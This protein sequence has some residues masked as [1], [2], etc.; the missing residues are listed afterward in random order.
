MKTSKT[1]LT[2]LLSATLI[3]APISASAD[4]LTI[5]NPT[6]EPIQLPKVDAK[7]LA[8]K[9]AKV[10]RTNAVAF[11]VDKLFEGIDW[12]MDPA[13]NQAITKNKTYCQMHSNLCVDNLADAEKYALQNFI[14]T[15]WKYPLT[16]CQFD[17]N[18][19]IQ[20]SFEQDGIVYPLL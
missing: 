15:E 3:L 13:N 20:C 9:I 19:N 5:P 6:S 8:K 16:G 18:Q 14:S 4:T 1:L 11:A 7:D 2:T 10:G 17:G 12:V